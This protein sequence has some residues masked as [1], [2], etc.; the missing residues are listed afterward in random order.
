MA[1]KP[2]QLYSAKLIPPPTDSLVPR[3]RLFQ[4]LDEL[5]PYRVVWICAPGGSGKTA[6]VAS[7]LRARG[8]PAVWLQLDK[9]DADP[10]TLFFHLGLAAKR[11]TPRKRRDLPLF[12]PDD[13]D[14]LTQFSHDFVQRLFARFDDPAILVLDN[15][16]DVAHYR[17]IPDLI[18]ASAR[19]IP[20][21]SNLLLVSRS[22]PPDGLMGLRA[23]GQLGVMEPAELNLTAQEAIALIQAR[24]DELPP[25]QVL[26]EWLRVSD[27]WMAAMV[28]WIEWLRTGTGVPE[29]AAER[30]R[31]T[32]FGY[33]T[34][35]LYERFAPAVQEFFLRTAYLP[36]IHPA[37]A[38][39]ISGNPRAAQLL[40][41]LTRRNF[42]T[43]AHAGARTAYQFH[44]VLREYLLRLAAE[45]LSAD[46]CRNL[47]RRAAEL[48]AKDGYLEAAIDHWVILGDWRNAAAAINRSASELLRQGR[49]QQLGEWLG[50]LPEMVIRADPWLLFQQGISQFFSGDLTSARTNL[51]DAYRGF[52]DAGDGRGMYLVWSSMVEAVVTERVGL[53]DCERWLDELNLLR[54]QHPTSPSPAVEARVVRAAHWAMVLRDPNRE[55]FE[56]HEQLL[57]NILHNEALPAE[58]RLLSACPVLFWYSWLS[59]DRQRCATLLPIMEELA[60]RPDV[61]KFVRNSWAMA[62]S[63]W[64]YWVNNDPKSHDAVLPHVERALELADSSGVRYYYSR[65]CTGSIWRLLTLGDRHGAKTFFDRLEPDMPTR[66]GED[67][68]NYHLVAAWDA[69]LAEP[70]SERARDLIEIACV[71]A[72]ESGNL[73]ALF[74][75]RFGRAQLDLTDG[76]SG[77]ALRELA[78]LRHFARQRR[79][80]NFL[81]MCRMLTAWV[82][83]TRGQRGRTRVL[84][85]SALEEARAGGLVRF[86]FFRS[87][88]AA[89]L[90]NE[91]LE[92][93]IERV[94]TQEL[95]HAWRLLAPPDAAATWPWALRVTCLGEFALANSSG[96]LTFERKTPKKPLE[97]LRALIALGGQTV[98]EEKL[99]D[100]LWPGEEGDTAHRAL[101]TTLHRLRRLIGEELIGV[102]D[103]CLSIDFG[104]VWVDARVFES[105]IDGDH[106]PAL[107]RA[108]VL[109]Q[110]H[111]FPADGTA[112]WVTAARERLRSKFI[113]A[114]GRRGAA[115]EAAGEFDAA[116]DCYLHGLAVDELAEALH[117]GLI[118]SYGA[119]GLAAEA[120]D[121]YHRCR[122]ALSLSLGIKPSRKTQSCYQAAIAC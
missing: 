70:G 112:A 47:R 103:G 8:L 36:I 52:K 68:A 119:M 32:L 78:A 97:L 101:T 19:A 61:S 121:A 96:P 117:Q 28:L 57:T 74:C 106:E 26:T 80:R 13:A 71:R 95:I 4:R 77:D 85:K 6:L 27:G 34:T 22:N 1:I 58:A 120:A 23:A 37:A 11:A 87:E 82:A 24:F 94:Y 33:L 76:R 105:A 55:Q 91:A 107:D 115:L 9:T 56:F 14:G 62:V 109:Y 31:E 38:S 59:A 17:R 46:E 25:Q 15:F 122:K 92:Q 69:W 75:C 12:T 35:E 3:G 51:A 53:D 50:T 45:K 48:L 67:G 110:G 104:K 21:G 49:H 41:Y 79:S 10:G 39:E 66:R 18:R 81:V 43:S 54:I 84:L 5:R 99:I 7:Y 65:L 72:E 100:A 42:F 60:R 29:Q 102:N 73:I 20:P 111:L 114:C 2:E 30:V 88:Q 108:L 63:G 98:P 93:G 16:E 90:F 89:A 83:F 118:R 44:P 113:R 86:P 116:V 40:D 64:S